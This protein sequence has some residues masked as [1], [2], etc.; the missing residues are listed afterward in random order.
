MHPVLTYVNVSATQLGSS[1]ELASYFVAFANA[2]SIFGRWMSGLLA[3]R[4]GAN[5]ILLYLI[6]GEFNY[7]AWP[8]HL[9]IMIPFTLFA[10][11][12]TY[13]WPFASSTASLIVVTLIYGFCSGTYVSLLSAPIMNLGGEGDVGRRI[14]MFMTITAFGAVAGPPISGAINAATGGF[15]AVGIYAGA[16][17]NWWL[18]LSVV[19]W[20]F[21]R[22]HRCCGYNV[23]RGYTISCSWAVERLYLTAVSES[24]LYA[25]HVI[26][27]DSMW[28]KFLLTRWFS[29]FR[30]GSFLVNMIVVMKC[31]DQGRQHN[32]LSRQC[33]SDCW[34]LDKEWTEAKVVEY[35]PPHLSFSLNIFESPPMVGHCDSGWRYVLGR[36]LSPLRILMRRGRYSALLFQISP[37]L[38]LQSCQEIH[39][40]RVHPNLRSMTQLWFLMTLDPK[41]S[42]R[43]STISWI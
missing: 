17:F 43:V 42:G 31:G 9:N 20:W 30:W 33:R 12:L 26:I 29:D 27:H 18:S 38:W 39:G 11:I 1:P 8:G 10:G 14:G 4:I 28:S 6:L 13:A 41:Q 37:H 25:P 2:S 5:R 22:E 40:F 32:P 19:F 24:W 3:D 21:V 36:M 15:K 23:S 35:T 16:P 7:N 34:M